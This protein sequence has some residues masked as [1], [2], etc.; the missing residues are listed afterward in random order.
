MPKLSKIRLTG[1]K[2][3]AFKKEHENSIFDLIKED[4]ADHSLFTLCNGGG[5][6]VMMQLIFQLLLP[7]TRWGKNNGN[8]VISMF[9]DQRNNLH[10]FTFHVALE[11][12][13]DTVPEKRLITG[14]AVKAIIKNTS[15]EEDEKTG[16]SYFLYT[17]EHENNGYYTIENLP[18]YD[19]NM[20]EAVDINVLDNFIT[21][22]RRDFIKYSQS[23]VRRKDSDYFRYLESRGIYRSEW[24]NLKDIN[25]L[26]GGSGDYFIGAS[27]NKS[28]FDKIIIPAISENIK[29][30][31]YGDGDNLIEMFRSNLSIT[32]DLPILIKREA[33]YKE[34]LIEIKPLIENADIGSRLI[35]IKERLINEGN[36]IYFI[37][38]D[39][40]LLVNHEIE[41]WE[42]ELEKAEIEKEDLKYKKD[43]LYYN[44]QK[45][46]IESKEKEAM[47]LDLKLKEKLI[48][49]K[50]KKEERLSYQINKKLYYKREIEAE[51]ASKS[52]EK[53]KLIEA[54][55]I[56]DIKERAECLD[57][58][59]EIEWDQTK[60]TWLYTENQ[61]A[62]YIN[63]TN[64]LKEENI[65]KKRKYQSRI[66]GLQNELNRFIMKEEDLNKKK[67]SLEKIYDSL[68]LLF[69][70]RIYDDLTVIQEEIK[71]K[72]NHLEQGINTYIQKISELDRKLAK[73]NYIL[74]SKNKEIELLIDQVI[75]Q[76]K[77]ELDLSKRI[78]KQLLE[79]Q[80]SELLSHR[81]V[82]K[83]LDQLEHMKCEKNEKL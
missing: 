62:A 54:L 11:W 82:N 29:N 58:E 6:G 49:I 47:D 5:K 20:E 30:Y 38:K 73:F 15:N 10:P 19:E 50:D 22:N 53:E 42:R 52:R 61:Y 33:D 35:D 81:W 16:L 60:N 44:Q 34:L 26:E 32:K 39:K 28:I 13:L 70:E 48:E 37:L 74:E 2:Y 31:S 12:I 72:I 41:K 67:C 24:V 14:I 63:Y 55:D 51:I 45:R 65:S 69:P 3:D 1:C 68:S 18:L 66:E 80:E 71:E 57:N 64:Q 59:I 36:D 8:K 4:K 75:E 56:S 46:D 40:D 17:H 78:A 27:D 76:E 25:K 83:K 23:S 77:Y 21:D 43:N 79:N 9:Y 7:E